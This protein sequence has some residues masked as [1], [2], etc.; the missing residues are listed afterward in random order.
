MK[1][2]GI[3]LELVEVV[4]GSFEAQQELGATVV[5]ECRI[6][7]TPV[8]LPKDGDPPITIDGAGLQYGE[9]WT[10]PVI[11]TVR[12][13]ARSITIGAVEPESDEPYVMPWRSRLRVAWQILREG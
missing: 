4:K 3:D 9:D 11:V 5:N 6:N 10:E 12:M 8:L 1:A 7:G 2:R 13:F